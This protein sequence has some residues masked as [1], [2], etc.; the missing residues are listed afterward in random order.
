MLENPKDEQEFECL[1]RRRA[2]RFKQDRH[3]KNVTVDI[4]CNK[5]GLPVDDFSRRALCEFSKV[6]LGTEHGWVECG[7]VRTGF[8]YN[9]FHRTVILFDPACEIIGDEIGFILLYK[10]VIKNK[11]KAVDIKARMS[12]GGYAS[13]GEFCAVGGGCD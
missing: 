2:A 11:L 6:A 8:I 12:G 4:T 3:C 7:R 5:N 9:H 10:L 13:G 1:M